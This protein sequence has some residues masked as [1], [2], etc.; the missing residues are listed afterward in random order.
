VQA[1]LNETIEEIVGANGRP[2]RRGSHG[3]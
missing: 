2:A 1:M 3:G